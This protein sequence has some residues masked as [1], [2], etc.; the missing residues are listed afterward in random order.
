MLGISRIY[1]ISL[2]RCKIL[3]VSNVFVSWFRRGKGAE[4]KIEMG[5][6]VIY[7]EFN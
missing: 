6:S 5:F 1:Q 4:K 2:M 3:Q 7:V